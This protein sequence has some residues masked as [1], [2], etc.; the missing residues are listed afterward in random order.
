MK[1]LEHE[2]RDVL[3]RNK[4]KDIQIDI[5]ELFQMV[6]EEYFNN[7]L[8]EETY[9][10]YEHDLFV[11]CY[12]ESLEDIFEFV[13]AVPQT[14]SQTSP[15]QR[16]KGVPDSTKTLKIS[17]QAAEKIVGKTANDNVKKSLARKIAT[18]ITKRVGM[19]AATGAAAGALT[20]PGAAITTGIGTL[21][22]LG[23]AA[24]DAYD[25]YKNVMGQPKE[26]PKSPE[27]KTPPLPTRRKKPGRPKRKTP[28]RKTPP[29]PTRKPE[30]P[31]PEKKPEPKPV[32][33]EPEPKPEPKPEKKPEPKPEKKPE[34][35]PAPGPATAPGPVIAP[36]PATVAPPVTAP[37]TRT[38]TKTKRKR[39]PGSRTEPRRRIFPSFGSGDG[40][41]PK[42]LNLDHLAVLQM[43]GSKGS[44]VRK[45]VESREDIEATPR[46]T[47]TDREKI[48]VV[49]RA[50]NDLEAANRKRF[51]ME[52]IKK[53]IIDES[54]NIINS[55]K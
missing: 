33:P 40:F 37:R 10:E 47:E 42:K 53:K 43:R 52:N 24:K 54:L 19:G 28:R 48:D 6:Q 35:K 15:L 13:Q 26:N 34:P 46:F 4:N 22:G 51:R 2:I 32:R 30:K 12:F 3:N 23:L 31:K 9:E 50:E 1:T 25:I 55:R 20:G 38:N 14:Q 11:Q 5:V 8:T 7:F 27:R 17:K 49:P 41:N 29:L 18:A 36:G 21:V 39:R 16:P 45:M 44:I